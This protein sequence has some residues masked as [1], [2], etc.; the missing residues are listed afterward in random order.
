MSSFMMLPIG[1]DGLVPYQYSWAASFS[2]F[3][4]IFTA[5]YLFVPSSVPTET[6]TRAMCANRCAAYVHAVTSASISFYAMWA[7]GVIRTGGG[8]VSL[9]PNF[10]IPLVA[11]GL[12]MGLSVDLTIG[13]FAWDGI[14]MLTGPKFDRDPLNI[15]HH[16]GGLL[17][18]LP[19]R[20]SGYGCALGVVCIALGEVS[21]P[22]QLPFM[23]ARLF[24]KSE[25]KSGAWRLEPPPRGP[26]D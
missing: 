4:V 23:T 9:A 16:V 3:T 1:H 10:D 12:W 21:N 25:M 11:G 22:L 18:L 6:M 13:Y 8:D 17:A 20:V 19:A 26:P 24:S 5:A 7:G 2:L 14:Y 15:A